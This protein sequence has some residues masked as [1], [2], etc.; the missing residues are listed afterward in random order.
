MVDPMAACYKRW[1]AKKGKAITL[2]TRSVSSY[3]DHGDPVESFTDSTIKAHVFGERNVL[4]QTDR[5][6]E[7]HVE[8]MIHVAYDVSLAELDHV[9][10]DG[11]EYVCS[12]PNI[13]TTYIS[14]Q[15][16]KLT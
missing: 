11:V 5:G 14:C 10:I 8:K 1:L 12:V 6:V 16:R 3:D 2:R 7:P 4:V 9:V 13:L 15:V